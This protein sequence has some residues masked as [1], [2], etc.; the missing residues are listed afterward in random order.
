LSDTKKKTL[1]EWFGLRRP[2]FVLDPRSSV[3]DRE[4]YAKRPKSLDIQKQITSLELDLEASMSPKK[5]YYGAYGSGKTHTLY[6]VLYELEQRLPIHV[7]FVECPVLKKNSTFLDLYAK[8][9][10]VLGMDFVTSLLHEAMNRAVKEVSFMDVEKHLIQLAD[11]EDLGRATYQFITQRLDPMKMWRWVTASGISSRE[12]DELRV[13]DDLGS[14]DPTR[15]VTIL[16][17]V[18]K[19]L[20]KLKQRSLVLVFDELDRTR[21]LGEEGSVTF[22]TA[23]TRLTEPAQTDAA[24]FFS[25]SAARIDDL[26]DILTEPVRSRIGKQNIV[27]IP[28]MASDDVRPF[29]EGIVGYVRDQSFDVKKAVGHYRPDADSETLTDELYPFTVDAI[30]AIKAACGQMILPREICFLLGRS[31][32]YSKIRGKHVVTRKDVDSATAG[33]VE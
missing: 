17:T 25:L 1:S 20:R 6:K 26:P 9:L 4:F 16:L 14:A 28:P 11:D 13:R 21:P 27:E 30:E 24:V 12:R 5:I 19:L 8:T 3:E 31:S 29:T 33:P 10:E 22:S 23:F 2:N 18:G 7:A 15:L 32:A